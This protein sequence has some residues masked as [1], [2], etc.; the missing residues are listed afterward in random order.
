MQLPAGGKRYHYAVVIFSLLFFLIPNQSFAQ[1]L[2]PNITVANK[3]GKNILT[4]N[5]PYNNIRQ[6]GVQRS[7]D[8]LFNYAT[9][10]FVHRPDTKV[11]SYTDERPS[12]GTN[13]YRLFV[14]LSSGTYFYTNPVK[15]VFQALASSSSSGGGAGSAVGGF[16]PSLFVYTNPEGNVNI[17]LSDAAVNNYHIRFY[18]AS[19]KKVFEID[20]IR[21]PLLII[22]RSNF[23]HSGWFS[24][25]LFENGKL[26]EHYRFFIPSQW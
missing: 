2:L 20:R 11:N 3:N 25:E 5:S 15:S 21:Q 7:Q 19:G 8:S 13:F 9:I 14:Q 23:L 22:D 17:S 12:G 4:W 6:I 18:D 10:G 26:K 16:I 1:A 24:F